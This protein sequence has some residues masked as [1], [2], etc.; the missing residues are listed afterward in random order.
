MSPGKGT[1]ALS[2]S[3]EEEILRKEGSIRLAGS[4]GKQGLGRHGVE[5]AAAFSLS[6]QV[7]EVVT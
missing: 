5:L 1:G 2:G 6:M 7:R 3:R 4:R